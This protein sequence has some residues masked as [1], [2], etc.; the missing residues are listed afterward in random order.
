MANNSFDWNDPEIQS[1]APVQFANIGDGVT[2][3]I[4]EITKVKS[5]LND[6]YNPV[7]TII[8]DA[9]GEPVKLVGGAAKLKQALVKLM[10]Q[11]G[12]RI[13]VR[14]TAEQ[15]LGKGKTLKYFSVEKIG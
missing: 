13:D 15:Q 7:L 14:M 11:R 12:D 2:G 9:S 3:V 8:D 1:D 10:P 6:A 4:T 5:D